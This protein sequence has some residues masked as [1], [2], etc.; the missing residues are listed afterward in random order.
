MMEMGFL[1]KKINSL[2]I[3]DVI[4][5]HEDSNLDKAFSKSLLKSESTYFLFFFRIF[6]LFL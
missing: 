5:Y 2:F 3:L 6:F 1:K 4:F